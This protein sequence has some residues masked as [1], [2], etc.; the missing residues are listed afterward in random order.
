MDAFFGTVCS[1]V[2]THK[3]RSS[4]N[5]RISR[6]NLLVCKQTATDHELRKTFLWIIWSII[7][8]HTHRDRSRNTG[9]IL[10]SNLIKEK[11]RMFWNFWFSFRRVVPMSRWWQAGIPRSTPSSRILRGLCKINRDHYYYIFTMH[12]HKITSNLIARHSNSLSCINQDL[13]SQWN[14]S[15]LLLVTWVYLISNRK[16]GQNWT[17]GPYFGCDRISFGFPACHA[18]SF[19]HS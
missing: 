15:K 13:I 8:T 4:I 9:R 3:N 12:T 18:D 17:R 14:Y 16:A 11:R 1:I 7:D 6:K 2:D 19:N 10:Q 5:G